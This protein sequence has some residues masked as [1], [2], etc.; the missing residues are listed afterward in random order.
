MNIVKK[1]INLNVQQPN[2]YQ[3]IHAMQGDNDTIEIEAAIWDGNKKYT[4]DSDDII[5]ID[6]IS[7][8]G[9]QNQIK[10]L[11]NTTNTVTFKLDKN[12][13][14]ENGEHKL[15][16]HFMSN[17]NI[18]LT[19]FP[20]ELYVTKAPLGSLAKGVMAIITEYVFA[21]QKSAEKAESFSQSA[22]SSAHNAKVSEDNAKNSETN[23]N[24]SAINAAESAANATQKATAAETSAANAAN[25]ATNASASAST[26][27]SK[28]SEA[29]ASATN[30]SNSANTAAT[31]ANEASTSANNAD[32]YAKE[33][34]SYAL[35]TGNVRPD[36][37]TDNAKYYYEQAKSISESL[38]GALHPMGTVT[39]ANLPPLSDASEG[40]MYNVSDQFT[41]NTDFKEGAG[42]VIPAGANVYKTADEKWDVLAGSPV[43]GIKGSNE[44]AYRKGNVNITAENIGAL[45]TSGGEIT[46]EITRTYG[47]SSTTGVTKVTC[48]SELSVEFSAPK[49]GVTRKV[50]LNGGGLSFE[51]I[52]GTGTNTS[53]M[54]YG[55]DN[56]SGGTEGSSD[57]ITS[58]AVHSVVSTGMR[59]IIK[60]PGNCSLT[61]LASFPGGAYRINNNLMLQMTDAP[62]GYTGGACYLIKGYDESAT[63]ENFMVLLGTSPDSVWYRSRYGSWREW[64]K[65]LTVNNMAWK[66]LGKI[67]SGGTL[68]V[69]SSTEIM[70][71]AGTPAASYIAFGTKVIPYGVHFEI[72]EQ[73]FPSGSTKTL[74]ISASGVITAASTFPSGFNYTIYYR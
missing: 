72:Q 67:S 66:Q 26:A 69:P 61:S 3:I 36:E 50:T 19:T 53:S 21:A 31:K 68:T 28:A 32:T 1:K 62:N 25:S 43:T 45:A 47:N 38:S 24:A 70:L 35:G 56:T 15:S 14:A 29:A 41:T 60:V 6:C 30:A 52:S 48:G 27:T 55:I 58:G 42:N 33:S 49:G 59:F 22:D 9:I 34:K 65:L 54:T 13:L 63:D 74:E 11:S 16:V 8:S 5:S 12:V 20:A 18:S 46:G 17:P 71:I 37:A 2:N 40:D 73:D 51:N 4:I 44:T 7:P 23:A 10:I 64:R 39:F 57:L